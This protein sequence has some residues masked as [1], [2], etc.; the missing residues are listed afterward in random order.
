MRIYSNSLPSPTNLHQGRAYA[1]ANDGRML[2]CSSSASPHVEKT[3]ALS[4]RACTGHRYKVGTSLLFTK[5]VSDSLLTRVRRFSKSAHRICVAHCERRT[6]WKRPCY[7][8]AH[9]C[10]HGG[11][12]FRLSDSVWLGACRMDGNFETKTGSTEMNIVQ[13]QSRD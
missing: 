10:G 11:V 1:T 12:F 5:N 9:I 2:P 4:L 3:W 6:F 13:W 8:F 7:Y